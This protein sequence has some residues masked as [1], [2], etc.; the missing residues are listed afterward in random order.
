MK[1]TKG[2]KKT[3][4][5][6]K[7]E[8]DAEILFYFVIMAIL[9]VFIL[10]LFSPLMANN[11]SESNYLVKNLKSIIVSTDKKVYGLNDEIVLAI[12]NYSE[13]SVYSEPCEYLDNFEKKVNE[14][15]V[16]LMSSQRE[17]IYDQSGFNRSKKV[18]KCIV[19]LPQFG[20]GTYRAS[21]KVYYGCTKPEEC[22]GS[23]NFYSNEFA[24]KKLANNSQ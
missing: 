17:K 2:T 18:T 6:K 12:E 14:S 7:L 13:R 4:E 21:V 3:K 20:E 8:Y 22:A 11:S 16:S 24:V 5:V 9:P 15:W 23:N 10:V 1:K 19:K